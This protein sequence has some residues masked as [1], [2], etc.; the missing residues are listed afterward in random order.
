MLN[1]MSKIL[2]VQ[3]GTRTTESVCVH[4]LIFCFLFF[5]YLFKVLRGSS[6]ATDSSLLKVL[7]VSGQMRK[8]HKGDVHQ[9]EE[10]PVLVRHQ[11]L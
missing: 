5:V 4:D 9:R 3:L 2:L 1:K 7:S 10:A 6:R 11:R 8:P